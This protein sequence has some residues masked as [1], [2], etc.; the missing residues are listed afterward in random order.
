MVTGLTDTV[1]LNAPTTVYPI[2]QLAKPIYFTS[3]PPNLKYY[4]DGVLV[5]TPAT[6]EWGPGSSHLISALDSQRDPH[7]DWWIFSSWSDGGALSHTYKASNSANPETITA[8]YVRAASISLQTVPVG[9]NLKVDGMT[10]PP[11]YSYLWG[12]GQTH[13]VEAPLEQTDAHGAVW[14]FSQWDDGATTAVRD[15]TPPAGSD[16]FGVRLIAMYTAQ[17]HLTID[18]SV[19]G[20]AV[21]VDGTACSTPCS[22]VR[23]VGAT[24]HV[25]A[26]ASLPL[27]DG[28]RQ[29]FLGWSAGGA[30][31]VAGDWSATLS[32][33]PVAISAS[34]HVMNRL[35]VAA[36]PPEAASWSIV[37]AS[38][39][40]FYDSQSQ[41]TVTMTAK[42]G[43][44]F[45]NWSGDL[46]GG[47]PTGTVQM[48]APRAVQARFD[49]VP[50]VPPTGLMNG[51]GST[52][53]DG[54]AAGSVATVFGSSLAA[55]TEV[56][57]ANPLPQTLGGTTVSIGSHL[58]A[59]YF[60]SPTQ[61]NLEIPPDLAIG[62]QTLTVSPTGLPNV[63]VG[64]KVVR[65]APGLF[66]V[67]V[68][69]KSYALVFHED[70]TLVT[71]ASPA[72]KGELLTLYG[73]GFGPT[74]HVRPEGFNVP[75]TPPYLVLDPVQVQVGDD[76]IQPE[77][78]FAAPG[79]IGI[80]VVQ[81]RLDGSA[82]SSVVAP[83][84]ITINGAASNT[85][86]LPIQ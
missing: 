9:L 33:T 65:N 32:A 85:L 44:R 10:L 39:D 62:S 66:P 8:S 38:T 21:T 51:A 84:L 26:P 31:P 59:L 16:F 37:P 7:L 77:K 11:P 69:D 2:F 43:Y 81:F 19:A 80:D 75:A 79:H 1:A 60:A 55:T 53:V 49:T 86:L 22:I 83:L 45:A 47:N 46:S 27:G 40:G 71:V 4:V 74:D 63:Q 20:L 61:I 15:V 14:D 50:Y 76:A 36:Q 82:P 12:I 5:T 34:Y 68:D 13:H 52:P 28:S 78:A 70:G 56:G 29:D 35:T 72:R 42:Q 25:S 3:D 23:P 17:A 54:V 30:A 6:L 18:S 58:L 67:I 57:P 64:F 24:V 41:V 48:N 73:T